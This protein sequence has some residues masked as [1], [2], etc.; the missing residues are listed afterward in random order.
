MFSPIIYLSTN[1]GVAFSCA[2]SSQF[3]TLC[4][5]NHVLVGELMV[6]MPLSRRGTARA[7]G[8]YRVTALTQLTR[9]PISSHP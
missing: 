7:E 5:R 9:L 1:K 2:R 6:P 4:T 3:R 8:G